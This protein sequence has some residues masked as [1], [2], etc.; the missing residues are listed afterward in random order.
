MASRLASYA[1]EPTEKLSAHKRRSLY[2]FQE[3]F[4]MNSEAKYEMTEIE[5]PLVKNMENPHM[6]GLKYLSTLLLLKRVCEIK[7][8]VERGLMYVEVWVNH[9]VGKN[10]ICELPLKYN[11]NNNLFFFFDHN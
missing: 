9:R 1:R 8:P 3:K 2:D 10:T 7:Q 5:T 6:G 4:G 11:K